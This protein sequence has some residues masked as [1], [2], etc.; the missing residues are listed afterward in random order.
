M[1]GGQAVHTVLVFPSPVATGKVAAR[2]LHV[3]LLGDVRRFFTDPAFGQAHME[4]VSHPYLAGAKGADIGGT[5]PNT[6]LAA[7]FSME[8]LDV[9]PSAVTNER[10]LAFQNAIKAKLP[11][12]APRRAAQG[13]CKAVL[14]SD[15][16][17]H[18]L[19]A[20]PVLPPCAH[21]CTSSARAQGQAP[22]LRPTS[23]TAYRATWPA[24]GAPRP[25]PP[26][27][28]Q[29]QP[30]RPQRPLR[31]QPPPTRLIAQVRAGRC[32]APQPCCC[33]HRCHGGCRHAH[34]PGTDENT[35]PAAAS[36][37]C[38]SPNAS[39]SCSQATDPTAYGKLVFNTN[40]HGLEGAAGRAAL[41][42][43]LKM[44]ATNPA[45]IFPVGQFGRMHL[46]G[47]AGMRLVPNALFKESCEPGEWR[48][49]RVGI[50]QLCLQGGACC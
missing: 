8:W 12:G 33:R 20:L 18:A 40:V 2:Q 47:G 25:S 45:S 38:A 31:L 49:Q 39:S 10:A 14:Q 17:R 35:V 19:P 1:D 5:L 24:T 26:R 36:T 28:Q 23:T 16:L 6:N 30:T 29:Q 44:L 50:T 21:S 34:W 48:W 22:T 13:P 4:T 43:L 41:G 11:V 3:A 27:Q 32:P 37:M 7:Q 42:Q 15:C 9:A 46:E